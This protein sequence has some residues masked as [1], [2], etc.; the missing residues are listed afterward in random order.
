[1]EYDEY[2][3]EPEGVVLCGA[4]AYTKKYYLN[5]DF[6]N[7]PEGIKAELK[8]MCVLYTEEV[9]GTI[10]LVFDEEGNLSIQAAADETDILFDEIGSGLKIRQMQRERKDLFEALET[11]YEVFS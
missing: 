7:L 1:M 3:P 9:G 11:Y 5:P 2:A 4:S 6:G 10:S 8:I